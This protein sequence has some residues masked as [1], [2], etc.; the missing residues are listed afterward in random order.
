MNDG[1]RGKRIVL[2]D[3]DTIIGSQL[4][5]VRAAAQVEE[6]DPASLH[7]LLSKGGS[8]SEVARFTQTLGCLM[9][10]C[11]SNEVTQDLPQSP[12]LVVHGSKVF[13]FTGPGAYLGYGLEIRSGANNEVRATSQNL[14][15]AVVPCHRTFYSP[16]AVSEFIVKHLPGTTFTSNEAIATLRAL[17]RGLRVR[18][19]RADKEPRIAT[20]SGIATTI[21]AETFFNMRSAHGHRD[22]SVFEYFTK[23]LSLSTRVKFVVLTFHSHTGKGILMTYSDQPCLIVGS[24]ERPQFFPTCVCEIVQGQ[25]FKHP[26]PKGALLKVHEFKTISTH[27]VNP[28]S[29]LYGDQNLVNLVC[30]ASPLGTLSL[31]DGQMGPL[32]TS[33]EHIECQKITKHA[34]HLPAVSD[35]LSESDFGVIFV[36]IGNAPALS[37]IVEVFLEIFRR[38]LR[39]LKLRDP[40]FNGRSHVLKQSASLESWKNDLDSALDPQNPLEK[41]PD[42]LCRGSTGVSRPFIV[43]FIEGGR[44][45]HLI[46]SKI[47]HLCDL[48]LGFQ[49]CCVKLSTLDKIHQQNTDNGI[50]RYACSILSKMFAKSGSR[51]DTIG[52]ANTDIP[53]ISNAT[54]LVGAHVAAVSANPLGVKE[55]EGNSGAK[56][57]CITLSS[58]PIGYKGTYKITTMLKGGTSPDNLGLEIL[59]IAHLDEHEKP[60]IQLSTLSRLVFYRSGVTTWNKESALEK[61]APRVPARPEGRLPRGTIPDHWKSSLTSRGRAGSS[62]TGGSDFKQPNPTGEAESSRNDM[63][64]DDITSITAANGSTRHFAKDRSQGR[65]RTKDGV[66]RQFS[67]TSS[68]APYAETDL[69]DRHS[70]FWET[71]EREYS[72]RTETERLE[73]AIS[74]KFPCAKLCYTSVRSNTKLKLCNATDQSPVKGPPGSD[75]VCKNIGWIASEG[76]TNPNDNEWF[77]LKDLSGIITHKPLHL[78]CHNMGS[79]GNSSSL[80]NE[81]QKNYE[82]VILPLSESSLGYLRL[83]SLD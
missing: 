8:Q 71:A 64:K 10:G 82:D 25:S 72:S 41:T 56:V 40:L 48:R 26:I 77:M 18:I 22:I 46:H 30:E 70:R 37:K 45:N 83:H 17:L 76:L 44:D 51:L 21:P 68:L 63:E 38:R 39:E 65:D 79:S 59:L 54:L 43:A 52:F 20:I 33:A 60:R 75:K 47:K 11:K 81:I 66:S 62:M 67:K 32:S 57:Y 58:K 55:Q 31:H 80:A 9:P 15:R 19:Q 49:S 27:K 2:P 53:P 42:Y 29:G 35:D 69:P 78:T 73:L 36:E 4:I 61:Q 13:D 34:A 12:S 14:L 7:G 28:N 6:F 5:T 74:S 16:I 23:G 24:E 1:V 50:D 3:E